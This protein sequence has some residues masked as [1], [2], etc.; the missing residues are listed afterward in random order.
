MIDY[1]RLGAGLLVIA[2]GLLIW[3]SLPGLEVRELTPEERER[4]LEQTG[5]VE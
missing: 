5:R 1:I 4:L 2:S 3:W